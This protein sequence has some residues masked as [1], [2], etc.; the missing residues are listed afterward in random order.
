M[1]VKPILPL[2]PFAGARCLSAGDKKTPYDELR[3]INPRKFV[4]EKGK[5]FSHFSP[6]KSSSMS[7][8]ELT[9]LFTAYKT[10]RDANYVAGE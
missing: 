8:S 10:A 6:Q 1:L 7:S 3:A 2:Y 4:K 9:A 5:A